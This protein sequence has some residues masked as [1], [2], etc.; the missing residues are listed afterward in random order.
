MLDLKFQIISYCQD[1]N[2]HNRCIIAINNYFVIENLY[3]YDHKI[4]FIIPFSRKQS[5]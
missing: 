5:F 2:Y 3:P 1:E 4:L